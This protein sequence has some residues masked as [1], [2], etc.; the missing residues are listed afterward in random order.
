MPRVTSYEQE[1]FRELDGELVRAEGVYLKTIVTKRPGGAGKVD[2]TRPGTAKLKLSDGYAL[3]IEI[4]Y[5]AAGTRPLEEVQ[6]FHGKRVAIEGILHEHTPTAM[7]ADGHQLQT[8]TNAY[9]EGVSITPL[10]EHVDG[11]GE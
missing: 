5:E 7:S 11:E 2:L 8:M 6:R 10:D 3:M 1:R 9:L 4:Y